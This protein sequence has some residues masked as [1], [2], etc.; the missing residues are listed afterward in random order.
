MSYRAPDFI[1]LDYSLLLSFLPRG[2]ELHALKDPG[3]LSPS[4]L[5]RATHLIGGLGGGTEHAQQSLSPPAS[6]WELV[7]VLPM[8]VPGVVQVQGCWWPGKLSVLGLSQDILSIQA[9]RHNL[10]FINSKDDPGPPYEDSC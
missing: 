3:S 4:R 10:A 9:T 1:C 7:P 5:Y 6:F 2:R 8:R